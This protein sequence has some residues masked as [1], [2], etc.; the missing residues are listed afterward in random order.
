MKNPIVIV[1]MGQLGGVFARGFLS[2]GHPVYPILR[3]TQLIEAIK[4]YP[5]PVLLLLAVGKKDLHPLLSEMPAHL[6]DRVGLLQNELLPRDWEKFRIHPTVSVVW[7]EKKHRRPVS[8]LIPTPIYGPH[9]NLVAEA[10][11]SLEIPI[12]ILDDK[13]ELLYQLV[14]KNIHI[15][16]TNIAGLVGA[17][18]LGG[19]LHHHPKLVR[20]VFLDVF[21]IQEKS[22]NKKLDPEQLWKDMQEIFKAHPEHG[23]RGRSASERLQRALGQADDY[24][25]SVPQLRSI[26]EGLSP[27]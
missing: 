5:E 26:R 25:L 19:L 23:S 14:L 17:D 18:T 20:A 8:P 7:F 4:E 13:Q 21:E 3:S 16:T 12:R 6:H 9:S 22:I 15:L 27:E 11:K 10:L 1:G 2:I 24:G